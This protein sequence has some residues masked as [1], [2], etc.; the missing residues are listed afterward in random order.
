MRPAVTWHAEAD[1]L[2]IYVGGALV[3]EI[4]R[5]CFGRLLFDLAK[6]LR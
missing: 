2:R 5:A 4:P 1:A 3:A 6:V